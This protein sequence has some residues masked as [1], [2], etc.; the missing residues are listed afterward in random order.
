MS[1]EVQGIVCILKYYIEVQGMVSLL[2]CKG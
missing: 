2:K 1:T